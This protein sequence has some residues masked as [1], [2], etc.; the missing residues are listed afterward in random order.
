MAVKTITYQ[1]ASFEIN[2]EIL[3]PTSSKVLVILHGWG[4]NKEIMKQAFAKQFTSYQ[5]IYI[6]MPGFGKSSDPHMAL[7]TKKYAEILTHFLQALSVKP[8]IMIGHSFGGKVATLLDA[9]YLV[10]LSSAGIL[11]QRTLKVRFLIALFKLLKPLKL[12]KINKFFV[13]KDAKEM[14]PAMYETFKY[15]VNEDFQDSFSAYSN[16]AFLFWGKADTATPLSSGEKIASL[17]AN[18]KFYPLE[19]DHFFFLHHAP[20]IAETIL[21]EIDANH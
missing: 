13:A 17:I 11:T 5:H 1:G 7:T 19:G 15:A 9:D 3:R 6:D 14:S 16:P 21:K 4:S 10:L 2:Y 8:D 12:Q 20:F 18:S